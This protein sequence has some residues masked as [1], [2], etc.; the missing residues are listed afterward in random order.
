MTDSYRSIDYRIRPAKHAERYMLC[1]VMRRMRFSH[2][3]D[4][5]YV[6]F[7]S[8]AFQDFRLIHR[9]LGVNAMI[10]I[11][12]VDVNAKTKQA[13]F[14]ENAPFGCVE[15]MFGNS[16]TQLPLID[17]AKPSLV[18]L[19]YDN[20]LSEN[21]AADLRTVGRNVPAGSFVA[22]TYAAQ[23]PSAAESRA[24]ELDRLIEQFPAILGKDTKASEFDGLLY[25]KFGRTI[26]TDAIDKSIADADAGK[27][28]GERRRARQVL[29]IQYRDGKQMATLA[30]LVLDEGMEQA[31]SEGRFDTLPFFSD[32]D[33]PFKIQIPFI[34]PH[35]FRTLERAAPG[36][37]AGSMPDWIP[38]ADRNAFIASYRYLPHF[39]VFEGG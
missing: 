35:E 27:A 33:V 1:D 14:R 8:V 36:F 18:W 25:A 22:V 39:G 5:Q 11:E 31:Y 30:W 15:M 26:L 34:T 4:Y 38:E 16:S 3:D 13:R 29:F 23:M 17:F 2:L 32:S 24:K 28:Q 19:D 12:D 9:L 7:G 10:S 6:G 37:A 21:M 20:H